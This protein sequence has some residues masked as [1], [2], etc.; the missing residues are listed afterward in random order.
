MYF[1]YNENEDRFDEWRRIY[2]IDPTEVKFSILAT[3][4]LV[5]HVITDCPAEPLLVYIY[6]GISGF[7]R[8]I[9]AESITKVNSITEFSIK[10]RNYITVS[11]EQETTVIKAL[12]KGAM[13][14]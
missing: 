12:Y 8:K 5:L 4:E 13:H 1:R 14:N 3:N 11:N 10:N 6:D 2:N 9:N 7:K